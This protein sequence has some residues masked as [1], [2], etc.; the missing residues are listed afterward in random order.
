[1]PRR[2]DKATVRRLA[3]RAAAIDGARPGQWEDELAAFNAE[4]KTRFTFE[5]FQGIAG[6]QDHAVWVKS[7]LSSRRLRPLPDITRDELVELVRRVGSVENKEHETDFWLRVLEVNLPNAPIS[8][9]IFYPDEVL[10]AEAG[11][12]EMSPEQIVDLALTRWPPPGAAPT[13]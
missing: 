11:A 4:A 2:L 10:G 1:M 7:V 5:D 12:E 8:D 9:L 6:G 13:T 3:Q